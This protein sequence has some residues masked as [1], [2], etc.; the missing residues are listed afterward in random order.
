[1]KAKGSIGSMLRMND[2]GRGAIDVLRKSWG[3]CVDRDS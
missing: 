2:P 3:V 1:M